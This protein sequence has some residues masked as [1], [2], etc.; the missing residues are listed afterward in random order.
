MARYTGTDG[1]DVL[2]GAG[3]PDLIRGLGGNDVLRGGG[4]KDVLDAGTGSDQMFGELGDDVAIISELDSATPDTFD[5]GAGF[6]TVDARRVPAS[7]FNLI[8]WN[9]DADAGVFTAGLFGD[10]TALTFT[11]VEKVIAT[12]QNDHLFFSNYREALTIDGAGGDDW[13]VTGSGNDLVYGGAGNDRLNGQGGR[14]MFY[15]GSGDDEIGPGLYTTGLVDGGDGIDTGVF[16]ASVNLAA[17]WARNAHGQ[18]IDVVGIE[19]VTASLDADGST[20]RGDDG[21]NVLDGRYSY[22]AGTFRGAGGD[23]T[24]IGGDGADTLYGNDGN[25]VL[26]GASG[27]DQLTGGGGADTFRFTDDFFSR[28][29]Q[30]DTITDFARMQGDKID[31]TGVDADTASDPIDAFR[32]IGSAAFN[33][34]AGELRFEVFGGETFVQAD[35]NGDGAADLQIRLTRTI[36]L[37][38]ADFVLGAGD[39]AMSH[40]GTVAQ[41]LDHPSA[42]PG[43]V[44]PVLP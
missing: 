34:S 2:E 19:N 21:A 43:Y 4:G 18:R 22:H 17:G 23:D 6:D 35:T 13:V 27:A 42:L 32:F 14:D 1:D 8:D 3:A 29:A 9:F 12:G 15:G 37:N 11:N 30:T 16:N 36:V 7:F 5:G 40:P 44:D 10:S 28:A 25:D 38:R 33:G 39:P 31:L 20:I 24:I 26:D 41:H